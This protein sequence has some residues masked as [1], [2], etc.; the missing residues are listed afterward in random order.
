MHGVTY[1]SAQTFGNVAAWGVR[2]GC[3]RT[4]LLAQLLERFVHLILDFTI[5]TAHR[6]VGR[7][8]SSISF[9][10]ECV[11]VIVIVIA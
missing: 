3:K 8:Q 11:I 5:S 10:S 6:S 9:C 4:E 7:T 1:E 2:V